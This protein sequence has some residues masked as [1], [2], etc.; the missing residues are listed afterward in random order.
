MVKRG[1]VAV[2]VGGLVASA[3]AFPKGGVI[4]APRVGDNVISIDG[5]LSDWQTS[6]FTEARKV[7][8]TKDNGFINVGT[9]DNDKDF[10]AVVYALYDSKNLYIGTTVVD[11]ATEKGFAGGNNWQNDCIE[12]WI[13]GAN[14]GGTMTDLGGADA[15]NYQLN[16]DVNGE[17]YVYRNDAAAAILKE[18]KS[19]ASLDGTNYSIEVRIPFSAIPEIKAKADGSMGFGFSFVDSDKAVWNHLLWQGDTENNPEQWGDLIFASE[20]LPVEPRAKL[21]V[22]W[23]ALRRP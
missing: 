19:A 20:T 23:G 2:L 6:L 9:F 13:D 1:L 22:A 10:S 14:D 21:A 4:R 11:D 5:K 12:I 15:D 18:I 8:L 3:H 17:P 7:V 16:V